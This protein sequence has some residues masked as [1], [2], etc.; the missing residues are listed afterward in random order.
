VTRR[1]WIKLWTQETLYG[2]TSRELD[3][4]EQAIWFKFLAAA[5]DSPEP[6]KIEVAPGVPYTAD[7]LSKIV[8]A[9]TDLLRQAMAKMIVAEKITVNTDVISITNWDRYQAEF[10]RRDYMRAYMQERRKREK[11]E[12]KGDVKHVNP[13][14]V[15]HANGKT[16]P[17]DQ[18]RPDQS[19]PESIEIPTVF[20]ATEAV[21]GTNKQKTVKQKPKQAE[22]GIFLDMVEQ[23]I[24]TKLVQ[25]PKL[26]G[27]I[28]PLLVK[29]PEATPESLFDCFKWLKQYDPYCQTR[30]SPMVIL[31]LPAK[32]PEWAA[33]K[34]QAGG[35]ASRKLPT[36]EE[37]KRGTDKFM[38]GER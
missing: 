18:T 13:A 26:M 23:H 19:I 12:K 25:R 29:F 32:Y 30:D 38:R 9:P 20:P 37:L 8:G 2:T 14:N 33:G 17:P 5:G 3:L 24:G 1:R 10:D 28:R 11:E 35:G 7:Q 27:Q 34:L 6:G 4:A 22:A 15:N 21:A 16:T 31:M 36:T